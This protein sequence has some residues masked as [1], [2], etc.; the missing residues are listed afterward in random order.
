MSTDFL[1]LANVGVQSL[2]PYQPGKPSDELARELGITDIVKLA[3]NENPLGIS[4][5]VKQ[6]LVQSIDEI[7]RYPD[8]NGYYLKQALAD[9]YALQPV[10]ITLGNGSNDLL[11]MLAHA[12]LNKTDEVIF[13]QY[14]FVVYALLTQAMGARA[15]L[16]PAREYGH[17]LET[18]LQA[19]TARTK[20]IFIAN[21]NNPTGTF[22]NSKVLKAFI[23]RVP[24]HVIVVLDE[25]YFEYV[26][27]AEDSSK[28]IIDF[29]HL[30][31]LRTFSK[32]YG[33]AGLRIGYS[34]SHVSIAEILNRIR[35]PFNCNSLALK[36]ALVALNDTAY[37][38]Q[39]VTLNNAGMQDLSAYFNLHKLSFIESKGNFISVNVRC[40]AEDVYQELLKEG[41]IVRPLSP[42]GLKNHLRVS[43]GT[44]AQNQRFKQALI[45]VLK[46]ES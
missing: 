2:Q 38:Q 12:F 39:T 45:H 10:Q 15:V 28:W 24:A 9:K 33:L 22:V 42:Y 46:L 36:A 34:L 37:L 19:I 41:V 18:M 43:I 7:T 3:S 6:M 8:A 14:S 25:A 20:I 4:A 27:D 16:V 13:A 29:P 40:S 11:E 35:Q 44:Y 21:P 23:A 26:N 30:I 32:A 31:V 17:D 5:K 1:K